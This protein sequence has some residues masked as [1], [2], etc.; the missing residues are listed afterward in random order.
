M[1]AWILTG[2]SDSEFNRLRWRC[3]RGMRE[4][5]AVLMRFADRHYLAAGEAEQAAFRGLLSA[6]DP[7]ILDLLTGR[8]RTDDEVLNRVLGMLRDERL[9]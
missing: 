6:P 2:L 9:P 5:D 7:E 8:L 1:P 3:R 4:L